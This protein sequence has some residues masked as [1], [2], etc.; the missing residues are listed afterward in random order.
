SL[1]KKGLARIFFTVTNDLTY[2]QRMQRIC[3]SLSNAGHSVVLVGRKRKHSPPLKSEPY[4]QYRLRCLGEKGFLFYA[5][6]NIRLFFFLWKRRMDGICAIDLDTII[7]CLLASRLKKVERIY[8]AHELFCEMK[9]IVSRPTM[10]L[11]W[12]WIERSTV[13]H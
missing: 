12:K 10:Y 3:R 7:P 4:R 2:D 6:Y 11:F 9:E 1:S 5:S 8:D 13:P